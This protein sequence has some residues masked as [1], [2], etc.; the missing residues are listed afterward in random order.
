[1]HLPTELSYLAEPSHNFGHHLDDENFAILD[2]ATEEQV[3]ELGAIAERVL[4][5]DHDPQVD[6]F[7]GEYEIRRSRRVGRPEFSIPSPGPC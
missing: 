4:I 2:R 3:N 6:G 7:L 5:N 1:M